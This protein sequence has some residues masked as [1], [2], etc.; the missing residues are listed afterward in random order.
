MSLLS[1]RDSCR[2]YD[3]K[4]RKQRQA[5]PSLE[6]FNTQH[7][8]SLPTSASAESAHKVYLKKLARAKKQHGVPLNTHVPSLYKALSAASDAEIKPKAFAN[9][10]AP[11]ASRAPAPE[12]K[13]RALGKVPRVEKSVSL[14]EEA[15]SEFKAPAAAVEKEIERAVGL[16][17]IALEAAEDMAPQNPVDA[18]KSNLDAWM[19][20]NPKSKLHKTTQVVHFVDDREESFSPEHTSAKMTRSTANI[21]KQGGGEFSM[22]SG[23]KKQYMELLDDDVQEVISCMKKNIKGPYFVR[24]I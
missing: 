20:A 19:K 9:T 5:P 24:V 21:L 1:L 17:D 13:P 23:A 15:K 14:Y 8:A 7:N 12:A 11:I 22:R 6:A 16:G 10:A 3:R 4:A 2:L 18:Y